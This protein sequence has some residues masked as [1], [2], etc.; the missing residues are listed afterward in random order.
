MTFNLWF[1]YHLLHLP[2]FQQEK[3]EQE[4][5]RNV[6]FDENGNMCP[7]KNKGRVYS[8]KTSIIVTEISALKENSSVL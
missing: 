8:D 4:R 3:S 1:G 7:M 2:R 6:Q 5:C